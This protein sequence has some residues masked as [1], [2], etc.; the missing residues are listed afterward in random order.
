MD[1]T[2]LYPAAL[3]TVAGIFSGGAGVA[4]RPS[5]KRLRWLIPVSGGLLLAL[6]VFGL[7]PELASEAGWPKAI[8]LVAAGYLALLLFDRFIYSICPSCSHNHDHAGCAQPLHGFSVPLA[9]AALV[10][11]FVDGWGMVTVDHADP[12]LG[13]T[14]ILAVVLHKIPEGVA[15][16]TMFRAATGGVWSAF[17]LCALVESATFAGGAAGLWKAPGDWVH[18]PLAMAAGMFVFLGLHALHGVW[19]KR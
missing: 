16:S 9:V 17:F 18:Y 5:A 15:L 1:F 19:K 8:S 4:I 14:V 10:H 6:A 13:A 12:K 11:A 3:A 2:Q 7:I